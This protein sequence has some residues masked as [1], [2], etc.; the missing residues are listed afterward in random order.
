MA[1]TCHAQALS[2]QKDLGDRRGM[3]FSLRELGTVAERTGELKRAR[4]LLS[5]SLSTLRDL[6]DR[7]GVAE[8]LESLASLAAAESQHDRALRL[9]GAALALRESIGSPLMPS[10]RERMDER[11]RKARQTLGKRE[12][13]HALAEGKSLGLEQAVRYGLE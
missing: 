8:S 2:I 4:E 7:E 3:A 6:G 12:A 10:D 5:E 13:S 9:A 11:L 1:R